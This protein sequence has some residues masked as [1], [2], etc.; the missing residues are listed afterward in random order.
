MEAAVLSGPVLERQIHGAGAEVAAAD[1][2]LHDCRELFAG[3]VGDLACVDLV[4]KRGG[5]FLLRRIEGPL[6]HAV[7][8]DRLAQLTAG[9]LME[10]Q[11]LFAGVDH[12]AV[13][14]GGVLLRQL[15]LRREFT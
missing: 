6:V 2:D 1:A 5:L 10:H 13:V 9:K 4:G 11:P 7:D 3:G 14:Q 12:L 8:D 15:C